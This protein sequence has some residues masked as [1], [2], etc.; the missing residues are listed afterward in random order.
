MHDDSVTD[1]VLGYGGIALTAVAVVALFADLGLDPE[2]QTSVVGLAMV[3]WMAAITVRHVR[4]YPGGAGRAWLIGAWVFLGLLLAFAIFQAVDT[5]AFDD[6]V[7]NGLLS[8]AAA[9]P[10]LVLILPLL[11]ASSAILRDTATPAMPGRHLPHP[12]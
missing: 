4:A 8:L 6:G 9:P 1:R 5:A 3:A 12:S 2:T 11:L 7:I 10:S